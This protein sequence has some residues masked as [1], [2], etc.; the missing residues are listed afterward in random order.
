MEEQVVD[1]EYE[2]AY[3][4][5]RIEELEDREHR[6]HAVLTQQDLV[7]DSSDESGPEGHDDEHDTAEEGEISLNMHHGTVPQ[8][9]N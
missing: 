4:S 7:D 1:R 2:R 3:M 8:V 5:K 6:L 9:V